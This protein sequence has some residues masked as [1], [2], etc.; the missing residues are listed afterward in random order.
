MSFKCG[1]VGMPNVGKSSIFN[2]LTKQSISA[3]MAEIMGN[4]Y[5][6]HSVKIYEEHMNISKRFSENVIQKILNE[7]I[8]IINRVILNLGYYPF[9]NF[10]VTKKTEYYSLNSELINQLKLND[11]IEN[12]LLN[13]VYL[14]KPLINLLNL[15]K[16]DKKSDEYN[17]LY[18]E[19]IS[20]GEYNIKHADLVEIQGIHKREG[21]EYPLIC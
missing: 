14:N 19:I 10:M 17:E 8:E 4:L 5:M 7:N 1:L 21:A 9:L 18:N 13:S 20:V 11:K 15:D 12:E 3:D 16:L 2:L 6:A